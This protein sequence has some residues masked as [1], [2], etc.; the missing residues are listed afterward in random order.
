MKITPEMIQNCSID[1]GMPKELFD[2][3]CNKI[4]TTVEKPRDSPL[5]KKRKNAQTTERRI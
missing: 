2:D 4:K 5:K 1:L 3:I